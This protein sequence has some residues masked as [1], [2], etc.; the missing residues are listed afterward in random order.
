MYF[1]FILSVRSQHYIIKDIIA[2]VI[3]STDQVGQCWLSLV[4]QIFK[5]GPKFYLMKF[6]LPD[7]MRL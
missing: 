2:S 4:N 5:Y 3:K 6:P 7:F 1:I